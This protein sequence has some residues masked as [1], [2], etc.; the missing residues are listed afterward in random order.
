[1]TGQ[2]SGNTPIKALTSSDLVRSCKYIEKGTYFAL[3]GVRCCVH[4]YIASPVLI[5]A[6]EI[7]NNTDIYDLVVQ[8]RRDLFAA[9][10]GLSEGPTGSCLSCD[11]LKEKKFKDVNFEY[12]GG[13]PLPGGMGIQHYTQCNERCAYCGYARENKFIEPQYDILG[14]LEQFRKRGKLRGNNWIDFS[15]GE[16]A[17]LKNL[18]EILSY[19]LKNKLGTVVVYSNASKYSQSIYDALKKN[20]VIPTTSLDTGLAS[21]YKKLRGVDAYSKVI[22][23]LIRYRNSG[24]S[25]LWLKYIICDINRTEDDLWSFI[26]AV[27][28][29]KPDKV[30]ICPDFPFGEKKIPDETVAFAARLWYLLENFTGFT[31]VD[32]TT[33][34]RDSE[35]EKYRTGLKSSLQELKRQRPFDNEYK[36]K[37]RSWVRSSMNSL[38]VARDRLLH[39]SARERILPDDSARL[40]VAKL[41]WGKTFGRIPFLRT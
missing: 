26:M 24:T 10:N 38:I 12:L 7:R 3:E 40:V 25:G 30:M 1:M 14:Y 37:E 20:K 18:D 29:I 27:L 31:P 15:G 34:F 5:T 41:A 11:H 13:E 32:Y 21:T 2:S 16:P 23:N 35:Y 17:L 6:D 19:L 4:A 28:A 36:L 9:I 33:A 22:G 8:R 39:S